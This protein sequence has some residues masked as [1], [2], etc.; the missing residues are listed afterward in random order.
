M[1]ADFIIVGGGIGGA[2]LAELLARGKKRVIVLERSQGPPPFLRPEILWPATVKVL[3]SLAP[4]SVWRERAI[5]PLHEVR[6]HDG[7]H[8]IP[9]V[10]HEVMALADAHPWFTNPNET[11]E[12]LLRLDGFELRR[13]V[14]VVE[15][16]KDG[17]RVAGVRAR[18]RQR[19]KET[20]CLAPWIVGD[21]GVHS[22]VRAAC[23]IGIALREFP[24][25]FLCLELDWAESLP[26]GVVHLWPNWRDGA[27]GIL[28][29]GAGSLPDG[30]GV[31]LV[32]ID[33]HAFDANPDVRSAWMKFR[34]LDP[35]IEALTSGHRFPDDFFRLKRE[36]GHA[37]HYGA[38]GAVLMGDAAHPVSPA[39]GQ[40]ANMS[41]A[42]AVV[43][44]DL[45]LRDEPNLVAEYERRRRPAN[46]RSVRPTR[47]AKNLLGLPG[48]AM[49]LTCR[50][51]LIRWLGRHPAA[52]ARMLRTVSTLFVE[53]KPIKPGN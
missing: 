30:K 34:G 40:G 36:W 13:G 1:T 18:D 16:L 47:F 2:V 37:E 46:E 44:A 20:E 51:E 5:Q 43:L 50:R 11:R 52:V 3:F 39:G 6:V 31:G 17:L 25:Q 12:Q 29:F 15:V 45:F 42:D 24:A 8:F 10:T 22:Q 14:E 23:G 53:A 41:V 33:G 9:L 32:L 35:E 4:E 19:A 21:D 28:A 26:E 48:W 38:P 49:P 7:K 27:S